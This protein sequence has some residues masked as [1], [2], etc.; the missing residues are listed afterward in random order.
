MAT[1]DRPSNQKSAINTISGNAK[2]TGGDQPFVGSFAAPVTDNGLAQLAQGFGQAAAGSAQLAMAYKQR[3]QED[4]DIE[5][6]LAALNAASDMTKEQVRLDNEPYNDA[7]PDEIP[8][9]LTKTF[10]DSAKAVQKQYG[11]G[12]KTK[13]QQD[14]YR[15]A[16]EQARLGLEEKTT[17][18]G[19]QKAMQLRTASVLSGMSAAQAKLA[20]MA[21]NGN[22]DQYIAAASGALAVTDDVTA[23]I[24]PVRAQQVKAAL[25]ENVSSGVSTAAQYALQNAPVGSEETTI[26]NIK[27]SVTKAAGVIFPND[28]SKLTSLMSGLDRMAESI[29]N[30]K[31]KNALEEAK[32]QVGA[33]ISDF[34]SARSPWTPV[35]LPQ[36]LLEKLPLTDRQDYVATLAM[37]PLRNQANRIANSTLP[38]REV[39]VFLE[40]GAEFVETLPAEIRESG[41]KLWTSLSADIREIS[42][43]PETVLARARAHKAS[44][45]QQY[46][47]VVAVN[48]GNAVAGLETV[49][50][51]DNLVAAKDN[52]VLALNNTEANVGAAAAQGIAQFTAILNSSGVKIPGV[53]NSK[54]MVA[55]LK[56]MGAPAGTLRV[57]AIHALIGQADPTTANKMTYAAN[58]G[59]QRLAAQRGMT[60]AELEDLRR[61][62][63]ADKNIAAVRQKINLMPAGSAPAE[64]LDGVVESVTAMAIANM[65]EGKVDTKALAA[66]VLKL[67]PIIARALN[68]S[69]TGEELAKA[70][71]TRFTGQYTTTNLLVP[72]KLKDTV[73][74]APFRA[75]LTKRVT[76]LLGIGK[77]PLLPRQ[78]ALETAPDNSGMVITYVNDRG[79][80]TPFVD[81]SGH[82][83]VISWKEVPSMR[84]A[85]DTRAKQLKTNTELTKTTGL[86]EYE[87]ALKRQEEARRAVIRG[88]K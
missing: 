44:G 3:R 37:Q 59:A 26:E 35:K 87:R 6:K 36:A 8:T 18:S 1:S 79:V 33:S 84:A 2:T 71:P 15:L 72:E 42:G 11:E 63:K 9:I 58:V 48:G 50:G 69:P 47:Q 62:V 64:I 5:A 68:T 24:D 76:T 60:T 4:E 10:S 74:S 61:V 45:Q 81:K 88:R 16:T 19:Y 67:S 31:T 86:T 65:P 12:L 66:N 77:N 38:E 75:E 25:L 80:R 49:V 41:R 14:I 22:V 53:S 29:R 13:R 34:T 56:N 32:I 17:S 55:M 27:A 70:A 46:Q 30:E 20:E 85:G 78:T 54:M 57:A 83:V 73:V 52:L 28:P 7:D 82:P 51:K 21:T 40:Q 23:R 43:D 39:A